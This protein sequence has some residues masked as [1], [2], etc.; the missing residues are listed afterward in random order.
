M[1]FYMSDQMFEYNFFKDWLDY[2]NPDDVGRIRYY[3]EYKSTMTIYQLSRMETGTDAQ[4]DEWDRTFNDDLRVMQQVKLVDAYPKSI[5]DLQLGHETGGSIQKM[6]TDIMFRKA[7]YTDFVN[8]SQKER[9]G[10]LL[11]ESFGSMNAIK[12]QGANLMKPLAQLNLPK[13]G[14]IIKKQNVTLP[15]MFEGFNIG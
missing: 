15:A 3:D 8:K 13:F 5:S 12:E 9:A 7:S 10:G 14:Q 4:S 11:S 2:I 6:S 1:S